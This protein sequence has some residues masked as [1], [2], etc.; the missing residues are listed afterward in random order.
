MRKLFVLLVL[1]AAA[2]VAGG[3]NK[4]G[5]NQNSTDMRALNVIVDAEALDV[6]VDSDVKF[7][8]VAPNTATS[9]ANF[10]SGNRELVLRS[11]TNQ[12]VLFD[13]S[14]SFP[15]D[16]RGTLLMYGHRSGAA[17]AF[18]QDDTTSPSSGKARVRIVN[19]SV[20]SGPVDVYVTTSSTATGPAFISGAAVGLPSAAGEVNGGGYRVVVTA[21][22]TQDV[23]FTSSTAF[24]FNSGSNYTV[25]ITP[26]LGGK[27][28]NAVVIEP[29]TS[30]NVTFLTNPITRVKG[31][32]AIADSSGLNFKSDGTTFLTAVPYTGV[33]SYVTSAGGTHNLQ[34]EQSNVPGTNIASLSASLASARDYSLLASGS[35]ASPKLTLI[36]DDNSPPTAGNVKIR[37]VNA[38]TGSNVDALVNFASQAQGI[39]PNTASA[40]YTI[41]ANTNYTITFTTPGGVAVIASLTGQQ[42]DPGN[43]YTA[44]VFGT[45]SSAQ[46]KLIRDR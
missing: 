20:D 42:L 25:A 28:V 30:G 5:Q 21:A 24:S 44:Y 22:G 16:S 39:A 27:L 32:N 3:C 17:A 37:F 9:Y 34:V 35:V 6:L 19:L 12:A 45:T 1:F 33:S 43:V 46:T 14:I 18:L 7:S 36:S 15:G 10:S 13:K 40:Y 8:A 38:V 41:A 26:S 11:A 29:G 31:V 4:G 2:L 23:V